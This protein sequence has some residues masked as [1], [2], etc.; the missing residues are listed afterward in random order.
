MTVYKAPDS[1]RN[2]N[3]IMTNNT[4][5]SSMHASSIGFAPFKEVEEVPKPSPFLPAHLKQLNMM[6]EDVKE[7]DLQ[8]SEIILP[9]FHKSIFKIME[10]DEEYIGS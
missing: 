6:F 9:N 1:K 7:L 8:E 2:F 3:S 5:V 10:G 4:N